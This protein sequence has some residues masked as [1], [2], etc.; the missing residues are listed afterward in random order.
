MCKIMASQAQAFASPGP[1]SLTPQK[2][3]ACPY[4]NIH[5]LGIASKGK[6]III[7]Q[8]KEVIWRSCFRS[9]TYQPDTRSSRRL[10]PSLCMIFI[11]CM[12]DSAVHSFWHS[13]QCI[14]RQGLDVE[15][16]R[17]SHKGDAESLEN[18]A[19]NHSNLHT[20]QQKEG[21]GQNRNENQVG[22]FTSLLIC[23]NV[24]IVESWPAPTGQPIKF[25]STGTPGQTRPNYA[26]LRLKPQFSCKITSGVSV[27]NQRKWEG[28]PSKSLSSP[29]L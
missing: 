14:P 17:G 8:A 28:V 21:S 13:N 3:A 12:S 19:L 18:K 15:T 2:S 25:S 20:K 7:Q 1:A 22:M 16:G 10:Q 29:Y 27:P 23:H 24:S 9:P 6:E 11:K 26:I 4:R 5:L